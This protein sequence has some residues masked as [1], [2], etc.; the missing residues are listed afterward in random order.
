MSRHDTTQA[1]SKASLVAWWKQFKNGKGD[2]DGKG[3]GNRNI[4]GVDLKEGIRYARV[5]ICLA[6]PNGKQPVCGY[7]PTIVA[8]CGM[9][10]KD[11]GEYDYFL[12]TTTTEG[13]FRLNGSAKR[14]K[15]LQTIF[16]SPP[17]YGKT[18]TWTGYSV[19]DAANVLRRY[20]NHLPNPVIPLNWY[21][22]F[23]EVHITYKDSHSRVEHYIKLIQKLPKENQQLLLYILDLLAV[24]SSKST[25]NLM[26]S[27]NLASIFQ[28][29]ILSHPAHDM[30]PEQYKLSQEV[31]EFLIDYQNYFLPG[32]EA[33]NEKDNT[34]INNEKSHVLEPSGLNEMIV[35]PLPTRRSSLSLE[36]L[37]SKSEED[38]ETPEDLTPSEPPS[39]NLDRKASNKSNKLGRS[40]TLPG[41]KSR[42]SGG[43]GKKV[44]EKKVVD[45]SNGNI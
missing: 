33:L 39:A 16:D 14:I 22:A 6:G 4:F 29:G 36:S 43:Q 12:P 35:P 13:I 40:K 24:F 3:K 19:H 18:L 32:G 38:M 15:E 10:L 17:T 23:R 21:D 28:P 27:K 8:K 26:P 25:Q 1:P 42:N 2:K 34:Y 37:R 11:Q 30:A 7:I 9:Y 31:L 5:P 20:L 41:K 44:D 45:G